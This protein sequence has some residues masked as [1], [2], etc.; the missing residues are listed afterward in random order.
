MKCKLCGGDAG[1]LNE[2]G[3]HWLCHA[4]NKLNQPTPCLGNKCP[5]CKGV[6]SQSKGGVMLFFDLGPDKIEQ[7]INSV[8]PPCQTCKGKGYINACS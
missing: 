7:A 8:F 5:D 4:R 1:R 3:V 6:G 2:D